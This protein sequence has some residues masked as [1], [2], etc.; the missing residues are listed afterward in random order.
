[1]AERVSNTIYVDGN[2]VVEKN[3][4]IKFPDIVM[5]LDRYII[6][7]K[8]PDSPSEQPAITEP[9]FESTVYDSPLPQEIDSRQEQD[10]RPEEKSNK[11][12]VNQI[13]EKFKIALA[14]G[15]IPLNKLAELDS[16]TNYFQKLSHFKNNVKPLLSTRIDTQDNNSHD[17]TELESINFFG[18]VPSSDHSDNRDQEE[19]KAARKYAAGWMRITAVLEFISETELTP[20]D[21]RLI[22]ELYEAGDLPNEIAMG[23][24]QNHYQAIPREFLKKIQPYLLPYRQE[25]ITEELK[26][27]FKNYP[28]YQERYRNIAHE[29]TDLYFEGRLP[30]NF[31]LLPPEK[32]DE[33]VSVGMRTHDIDN[34]DYINRAN[35]R[36][37]GISPEEKVE[38]F[39]I[40][41]N[42]PQYHINDDYFVRQKR[43]E[44]AFNKVKGP[45]LEKVRLG[46]VDVFNRQSTSRPY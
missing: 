25:T 34:F 21:R 1:M 27:L 42:D 3:R 23:D 33:E 10:G 15:I 5:D 43:I 6:G 19:I 26:I 11:T 30:L 2:G 38:I 18:A 24:D 16:I 9:P 40:L 35:R 17:D 29:I 13:G 12:W 22:Y 44:R 37:R 31:T 41:S 36:M 28:T 8:T 4:D 7:P 14:Q 45:L 39:Q 32:F 20:V 46:V